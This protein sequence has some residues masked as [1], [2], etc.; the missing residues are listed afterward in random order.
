[1]GNHACFSQHCRHTVVSGTVCTKWRDKTA[2]TSKLTKS[3]HAALFPVVHP[4]LSLFAVL[5][6]QCKWH[7]VSQA[8]LNQPQCGLKAICDGIGCLACLTTSDNSCGGHVDSAATWQSWVLHMLMI[9]G[10]SLASFPGPFG[11]ELVCLYNSQSFLLRSYCL[12]V[13]L[14]NVASSTHH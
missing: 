6:Y 13:A 4:H 9:Q 10:M 5:S 1:M 8:S 3:P 7:I 11:N 12:V 14:T 2:Y